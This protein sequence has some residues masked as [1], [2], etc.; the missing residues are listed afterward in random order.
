VWWPVSNPELSEES[1]MLISGRYL[2]LT[3]RERD[4]IVLFCFAVFSAV[5]ATHSAA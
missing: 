5:R 4:D 3:Q 2:K 1:T